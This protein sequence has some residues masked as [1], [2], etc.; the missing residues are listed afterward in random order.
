VNENA[1]VALFMDEKTTTHYIVLC[2]RPLI[3][4][5]DDWATPR[6]LDENVIAALFMDEK[7]S[8]G[9]SILIPVGYVRLYVNPAPS[10][11]LAQLRTLSFFSALL[12]F[13]SLAHLPEFL[14]FSRHRFS[15]AAI[16]CTRIA[17]KTRSRRRKKE[18]EGNK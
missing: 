12:G 6:L 10:L 16:V 4:P 18:K 17:L 7:K 11:S 2:P 13:A 8:S 15:S 9:I 14:V 1:I 3:W 5:N